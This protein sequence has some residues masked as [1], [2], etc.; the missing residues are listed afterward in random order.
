MERRT[1][2]SFMEK[3]CANRSFYFSNAH[4]DGLV[5]PRRRIE[6]WTYFQYHIQGLPFG[7]DFRVRFMW[8]CSNLTKLSIL[9]MARLTLFHTL[10][11]INRY[12]N[13]TKLAESLSP[14]QSFP[15]ILVRRPDTK[16]EPENTHFQLYQP[17]PT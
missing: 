12:L 13:E 7:K 9:P 4:G 3:R 17:P 16:V 11:L 5:I 2:P 10:T 14:I 8:I 6:S 15:R 1:L